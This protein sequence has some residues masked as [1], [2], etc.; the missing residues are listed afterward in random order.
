M[1]LSNRICIVTGGSSGIGRGIAIEF[2]REGA[3]VIIADVQQ[4][5]KSGK[6]YDTDVVTPTATEIEKL[7]GEATF[8]QTDVSDDSQVQHMIRQTVERF[9]GL[10][11]LVNN[12][13]ICIPGNSQELSLEDW[14]RITR[15]NYR[16]VFVAS[17]FGISHLKRS[18]AGRIINI[19]SIQA[20][21]GGGGPAYPGAKAAV[22]NLSRDLAL[23]LAP[24]Q[25]TV[26]SV[27][28]GF[29]ESAIQDYLTEDDI[30]SCREKTVLPRFGKPRDIA[31]A[32][33][34]LASDDAEWITGTSLVVD[35]GW[36]ANLK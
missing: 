27:C 28:P 25:I 10:D 23:E 14:D 20:H 36:L 17:K 35:G 12:A 3:K 32:C 5:P 2:A 19:S 22:V 30:K 11:I 8:I 1:I 24:H 21:R 16:A 29:I 15:I 4:A 31:R 34:F 18:C 13:G 26:N 7:G 9:G 6:Y 33:V